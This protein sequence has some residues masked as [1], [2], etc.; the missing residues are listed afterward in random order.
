MFPYVHRVL[1][2][3][4]AW[5][6]QKLALLTLTRLEKTKSRKLQRSTEQLSALVDV[7]GYG[8]IGPVFGRECLTIASSSCRQVSCHVV[9]SLCGNPYILIATTRRLPPNVLRS[10]IPQPF[11][12]SGNCRYLIALAATK[13]GRME[14]ED[15]GSLTT[16][17]VFFFSQHIAGARAALSYAGPGA[18]RSCHL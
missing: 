15:H 6:V 9:L 7:Y 16:D 8:T 14:L 11:R 10:S 17:T 18:R 5:A 4:R 2:Q 12:P 3:P 13:I 1:R